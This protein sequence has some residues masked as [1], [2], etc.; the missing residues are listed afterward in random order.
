MTVHSNAI[1]ISQVPE[2]WEGR[3]TYS[4]DLLYTYKEAMMTSQDCRDYLER[5]IKQLRRKLEI[6]EA[7]E[8]HRRRWSNQLEVYEAMLKYLSLY[9]L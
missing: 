1:H 6:Q 5:K 3:S 9:K 2:Q 7:A 8:G 4:N